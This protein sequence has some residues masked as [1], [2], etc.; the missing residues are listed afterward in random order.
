MSEPKLGQSLKCAVDLVLSVHRDVYSMIA[1]LD[2]M[3]RDRGWTRPL[4]DSRVTSGLSNGFGPDYWLLQNL[5]RIYWP[6]RETAE[7]I[8]NIVAMEIRFRLGAEFD[9][10]MCL[11]AAAKYQK[12]TS[13]EEIWDGWHREVED[14]IFSNLSLV[15]EPQEINTRILNDRFLPG[16]ISGV[17]YLIPLCDLSGIDALKSKIIDPILTAS[18]ALK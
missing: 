10:P 18:A 14:N 16:T 9:E 6:K 8:S 17:G 7:N 1:E 15:R 5:Y 4:K 13:Y 11:V 2:K 12:P 3:M